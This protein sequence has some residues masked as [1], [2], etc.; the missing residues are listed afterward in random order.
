M[1]TITK[2]KRLIILAI[3]VLSFFFCFLYAENS[4]AEISTS[5][6]L[7]TVLEKYETATSSWGIKIEAAATRL[8]VSLTA[9]SMVWTFAQLLFHRSSFSELFGEMIRF[10]VFTGFYLWLLRKAPFISE[11]IIKS[12]R[13]LGEQA[14][15]QQNLQPSKIVDIG[16]EIFS[17]AV[18]NIS[19]TSP[20]I[21]SGC[22]IV[23]IVVLLV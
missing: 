6:I 14:S 22:L 19:L 17:R 1:S 16:F 21:T 11:A 3:A 9:I 5:N 10:M 12:L 7:N 18:S 20:I 13:M 2:Q 4:F 8:F 15:G 23:S